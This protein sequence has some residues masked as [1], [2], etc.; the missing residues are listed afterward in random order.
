MKITFLE[1]CD[2][3]ADCVFLLSRQYSS[4]QT[5]PDSVDKIL[6][7]LQENYGNPVQTLS[8]SVEPVRIVESHILENLQTPRE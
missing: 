1:Q 2:A 8:K 4:V 5:V 6:E 7:G 3:A